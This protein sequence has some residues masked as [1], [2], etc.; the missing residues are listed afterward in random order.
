MFSCVFPEFFINSRVRYFS[1]RKE[2]IN[3]KHTILKRHEPSFL[4]LVTLLQ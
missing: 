3:Q 4:K 2:R 1:I